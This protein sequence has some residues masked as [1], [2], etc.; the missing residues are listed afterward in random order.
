MVEYRGLG[1]PNRHV[2]ATVLGMTSSSTGLKSPRVN[3]FDNRSL[4]WV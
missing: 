4:A 3:V 2:L 1:A